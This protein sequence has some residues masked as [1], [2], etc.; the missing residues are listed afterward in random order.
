MKTA[1][2][3]EPPSIKSFS[4]RIHE[5]GFIPTIYSPDHATVNASIIKE[6]KERGI[7]IIPWTVNDSNKIIEL[8]NMGVDGIISDYPDLF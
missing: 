6:C 3:Y 7:K 8:K 1:Y 2:L 4:T 5:L